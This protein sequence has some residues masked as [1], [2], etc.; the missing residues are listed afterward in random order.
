VLIDSLVHDVRYAIR[1]IRRSPLFAASVAA[2]IGLGLGI[3]CSAFTIVN[4]YLLR[5]IDLPDAHQLY[6]LTWDTETTQRHRF[7]LADFDNI[8]RDAP[9]FSGLVAA[10]DVPTMQDEVSLVGLLVTGNYFQVLGGRPALGRWISPADAAAPGSAPVVVLSDATW[11]T[12]YAADPAIVG[13]AI[14]LG[15]QRFDVVGVA[16][17]GFGLRGELRMSF[18]APLTM[19]GAFPGTDLNA[20]SLVVVGRLRE[21]ATETQARA[22]FDVWLRQQFR[23][24]SDDKATAARVEFE[25]S[26]LAV[27]ALTVT[28]LALLG[29]AFS[30]VLLVACANVTNLLLAR[31]LGRQ[32]E[33]GVRLALGATR[34][35]VAR[36]LT[37]ESLVLAVP[38]AA[39]GLALTLVHR[40]RLS[41]ADPLDDPQR[42]W[43]DRRH[44]GAPRAGHPCDDTAL[45]RGSHVGGAGD[46][47]PSRSRQSHESGLGIERRDRHGHASIAPANRAGRLAD[48]SLCT[49]HRRRVG[50]DR[51]I[52]AA[53]QSGIPASPTSA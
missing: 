46:A 42:H 41:S 23:A 35:R 6:S 18:W 49:V 44:H 13:K 16:P 19:A 30:L 37:I 31:A 10:R 22:W 40:A 25:G 9:P 43:P 8:R 48:R 15:R 53:G 2:T 26:R 36:Q 34:W 12:R 11:R 1:G 29:S 39:V 3:L 33:I 52:P 47:G 17:P 27:N 20:P 4:A 50:A 7:T 45:P 5:P 24:G 32:R 28:L 21:G 14:T 51:R 38:A